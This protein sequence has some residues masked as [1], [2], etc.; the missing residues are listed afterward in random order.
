MQNE[1]TGTGGRVPSS[2]TDRDVHEATVL[3]VIIT[4]Y[5]LC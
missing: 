4:H 1:Q 5:K 3:F 2:I